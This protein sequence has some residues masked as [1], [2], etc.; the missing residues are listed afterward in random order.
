MVEKRK[1]FSSSP[2]AIKNNTLFPSDTYFSKLRENTH[3]SL[4]LL[5]EMK[6]GH[7]V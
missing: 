2:L 6:T 4:S 5:R 1:K 3:P 7:V